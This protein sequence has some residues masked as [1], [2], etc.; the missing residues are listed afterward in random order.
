M[1]PAYLAGTALLLLTACYVMMILRFTYPLFLKRNPVTIP[2]TE[3]CITVIVAARNEEPNITACLESILTQDYPGDRFGVIVSD[4]HSA[5]RTRELALEAFA[6]HPRI[7][8]RVLDAGNDGSNGKKRAIERA[9]EA[10]TGEMILTTDADTLRGPG[11]LRSMA[12]EYRYCGAK[13]VTGPVRLEG[14]TLF[15]RMQRIEFL[16]IMGLTAGAAS[17]GHPLMCNGANLLYEK[18]AFIEC[19]GFSG[20]LKFPSGDDQFLMAAFRRRY[21]KKTVAFAMRPE[22]IV[23]T[24]AEATF[25][26]FLN[27]RMRWVSKSKGYREP[28]IILT[29]ALTWLLQAALLAVLVTGIFRH[30]LLPAALFC[31]VVKMAA[32]FPLVARMASFSGVLN[33][34]WMY[35]PAQ[36][37]QLVYVP[38]TGVAGLFL[39]YRWKGRLIRA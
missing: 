34:M 12:D 36:I 9:I 4:D 3:P 33:G 11:W 30:T 6:R 27:Q 26:G 1:D 24:P 5:D 22:A 32:D 13:M 35:V 21:G 37:F 7:A 17:A 23:T 16:G 25:H 20:N 14:T 31:L 38:L 8:S 19:G 2:G 10:A 28:L 39:P 15:Q 18:P 29:G